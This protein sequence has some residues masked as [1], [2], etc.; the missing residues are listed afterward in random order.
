MEWQNYPEF[1]SG[2]NEQLEK[3]ETGPY[4]MAEASPEEKLVRRRFQ[5]IY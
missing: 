2:M 5:A 1:F 3:N 4:Q